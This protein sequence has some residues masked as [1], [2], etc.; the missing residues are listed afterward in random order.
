MFY[1]TVKIGWNGDAHGE[2]LRLQEAFKD[3]TQRELV[4]IAI[5]ELYQKFVNGDLKLVRK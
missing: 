5:D 3:Y 2:L 1:K 4:E